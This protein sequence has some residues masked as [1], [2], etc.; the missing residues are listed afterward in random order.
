MNPSIRGLCLFVLAC[1]VLGLTAPGCSERASRVVAPLASAPAPSS[2]ANALELLRYDWVNRAPVSYGELFTEDYRFVFADS[3][4]AGNAFR[5]SPWGREDELVFAQNLFVNGTTVEPPASS[6]TLDFTMPPVV[7]PDDRAGKD[8]RWHKMIRVEF[9]LRVY[10]SVDGFEVKGAER[11]YLVRGDSA[12]IPPE[13]HDRGFGPDSARWWVERWVDES[14]QGTGLTP[15]RLAPP[16]TAQ[17][18]R[19]SSLGAI[20]VLYR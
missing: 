1:A 16:A 15:S 13:L 3:D 5:G 14:L 9:L 11:F 19:R 12:Q 10:R 17:P 18:T 20:K 2:P 4:S 8:E 7:V 6:I